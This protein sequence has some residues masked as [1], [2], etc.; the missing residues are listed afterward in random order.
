MKVISTE[1][2]EVVLLE[3]KIHRDERGLTYES[4]N[5]RMFR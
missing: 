1:L 4:F 3:P 2:P 5:Q